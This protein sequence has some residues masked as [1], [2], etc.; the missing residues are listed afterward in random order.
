MIIQFLWANP[1]TRG[2]LENEVIEGKTK[3][4]LIL[5]QWFGF[6]QLRVGRV[7]GCCG[8]GNELR[9]A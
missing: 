9:V 5:K 7:V 4:K 8:Y 3:F 2:K 6:M 1:K